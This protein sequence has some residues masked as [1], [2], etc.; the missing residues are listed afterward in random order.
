MLTLYHSQPSRSTS[1]MQL[2]HELGA[3]DQVKIVDVT[4]NRPDGSGQADPKNPHPEGK[5]PY[6]VDGDDHLR[7]RM[8][9]TL[10]LTDRF[11]DGR[12]GRPVGHPQRG[13]YLSWLFW[14][15]GVLEPLVFLNMAKVDHP[16]LKAWILDLDTAIQRLDE[17]LSKQ[18][19]LMG[20]AFSAVD[21]ALGGYFVRFKSDVPTTPA[22]DDWA[23][24][25]MDRDSV[26]AFAI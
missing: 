25:C 20:D 21:L 14:S 22:I 5:V 16:L 7:E 15:Q 1:I 17:V 23:A 26:R 24:R 6:L 2:L 12:L 8:A 3:L 18:P 11:D 10:Y 13:E 9:I 4:I 19:Y